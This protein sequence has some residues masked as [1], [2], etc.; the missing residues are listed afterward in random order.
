MKVERKK[1]PVFDQ[2]AAAYEQGLPSDTNPYDARN[3]DSANA[4]LWELGW[5]WAAA[6]AAPVPELI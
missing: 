2:G 5:E 3:G 6:A 1:S 4:C